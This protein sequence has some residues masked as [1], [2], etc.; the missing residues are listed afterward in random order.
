MKKL[1]LSL[2]AAILLASCAQTQKEE[3]KADFSFQAETFADLKLIRYQV[4][5]FE[6]LS[7]QQQKFVYFSVH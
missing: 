6:K 5:G 4:P 2:T 3:V 1:I 7:L